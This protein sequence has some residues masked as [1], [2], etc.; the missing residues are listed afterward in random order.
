MVPDFRD[1]DDEVSLPIELMSFSA[2]KVGAYVQ[3]DWSTATEINND[4]FTVERLVV[5]ENFENIL[6]EQGEGNSS[7]RLDYSRYDESPQVGYNYYRLSQTD[8]NG[9][10]ESFNVEVVNFDGFG[11]SKPS[12]SIEMKVYPNPTDGSMLTLIVSKLEA[13]EVALKIK[14]AEGQLII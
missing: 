9:V 8:V 11:E 5:G 14:T 6:T 10:S 7:R 2:S 1:E 12:A 3:L 13:G 4:Y